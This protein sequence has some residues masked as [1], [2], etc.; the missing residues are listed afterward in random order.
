MKNIEILNRH[1]IMEIEKR[2]KAERVKTAIEEGAK[3]VANLIGNVY[4][5]IASNMTV[6]VNVSDKK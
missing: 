6:N 2:E 1:Q 4:G 3:F 5:S